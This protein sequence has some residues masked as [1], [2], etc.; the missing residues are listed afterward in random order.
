MAD[1]ATLLAPGLIPVAL[2]MAGLAGLI[3]GFSGFG[4]S[5]AAV[6]L[7]SLIMPPAKVVPIVLLLQF[8]ISLNGLRGA[9]RICD[10]RSIRILAAGALTATPFGVW[11]L[12]HL[13]VAPAR[14]AIAVIVLIA[15]AVLSGGVRMR[16]APSNR[17]TLP[18]GVAAGLFN[19]LAGMP[20]PPVIAFYLAAPV[21]T[22]VARA[23]MIV[24][25]LATSGF[26]LIPL[27]YFGTLSGLSVA[28][29]LCGLPLVWLG[30]SAGALLYRRSPAAHYKIAAIS[31]LVAAAILAGARALAG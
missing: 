2:G 18:F 5:I 11:A 8:F 16:G 12:A 14:M 26:A 22:D 17:L 20:G 6:P 29:A 9:L 23:S 27:T 4:L 31:L 24:F 7:L 10:W 3:R 25:F 28:A 1:I 30:S 13:P 15:V 19:G 21:S